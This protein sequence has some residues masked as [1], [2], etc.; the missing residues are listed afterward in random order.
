[1]KNILNQLEKL[2]ELKSNKKLCE[3]AKEEIKKFENDDDYNK[4]QIG[5]EFTSELSENFF[6]DKYWFNCS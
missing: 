2:P 1:M 3:I 5:E 4:Y 6:I